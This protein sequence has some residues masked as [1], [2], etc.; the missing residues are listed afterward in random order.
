[1]KPKSLEN[2]LA[3]KAPFRLPG[4]RHRSDKNA[5]AE[6]REAQRQRADEAASLAETYPQLKSFKL[7]LEFVNREGMT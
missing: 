5:Y 2:E 6:Y 7:K 4:V 3:S 1:M